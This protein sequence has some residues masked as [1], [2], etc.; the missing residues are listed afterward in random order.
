MIKK[1]CL[2]VAALAM[3]LPTFVIFA[4]ETSPSFTD[5]KK[6]FMPQVGK[7]ITVEGTLELAK[8]GWWFHSRV[9]NYIHQR[10]ADIAKMNLLNK[11]SKLC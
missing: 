4:Q 7:K 10:S 6:E 8:L 3:L 11:F 9:G 2:T 1:T 5:F